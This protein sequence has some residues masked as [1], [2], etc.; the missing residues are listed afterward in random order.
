MKIRIASALAL[1]T[2]ILSGSSALAHA[3][4]RAETPAADAFV[5]AAPTTLAL[6]FSEGVEIKLSGA[7][8]KGADDRIVP[9]GAP[10]LDKNNDKLMSVPVI[11][12]I[13]PGKYIVEWHTLSKDGHATRGSYQFTV[14]P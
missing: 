3:H 7:T 8:L 2:H 10:S 14:G 6:A 4:L 12:S 9:T 11:G 13:Q 5:S 1:A